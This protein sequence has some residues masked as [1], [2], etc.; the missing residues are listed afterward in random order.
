MYLWM[1]LIPDWRDVADYFVPDFSSRPFS[2]FPF[3]LPVI[4]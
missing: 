2:Y 3:L 1:A 4:P